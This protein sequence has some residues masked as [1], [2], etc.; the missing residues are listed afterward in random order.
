MESLSAKKIP[1]GLVGAG[2]MGENHLRNLIT[3]SEVTIVGV[4]MGATNATSLFSDSRRLLASAKQGFGLV[5]AQP[6]GNVV[7]PVP[8]QRDRAPKQ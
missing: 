1:I 8:N 6:T 5:E 2:F 3:L 7:A 4:I